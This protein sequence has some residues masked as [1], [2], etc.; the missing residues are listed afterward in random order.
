MSLF[1]EQKEHVIGLFPPPLYCPNGKTRK[2]NRK[3][4]NART[5]SGRAQ[6]VKSADIFCLKGR[7][8]AQSRSP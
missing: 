2:T 3:R 8:R 6:A 4:K 1:G 5:D 7:E